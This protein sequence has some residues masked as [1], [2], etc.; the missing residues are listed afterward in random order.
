MAQQQHGPIVVFGA[1]GRAGLAIASE[2]L[3]RRRRVIGVVRDPARHLEL[4]A[5]GDGV[6]LVEGDLTDSDSVTPVMAGVPG[7][8]AVLVSAVTPFSAP[9]DSFDDF[10][11]DYYVHLVQNLARAAATALCRVI[12]IGHIATLRVGGRRLFEDTA[13]F[14]EFLRPFAEARLRGL[15]AWQEQATV[16]WLVITPPPVL[17][18]EASATGRYRLAGD[19]LDAGSAST[20]LSYVDLAVAVMDQID[21]PTF[22]RR[23]VTAYG[24][25]ADSADATGTPT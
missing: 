3:R 6:T 22:H 12:E 4:A 21:T 11:A 7:D 1:G 13:A 25:T 10:D 8:V 2:S 23:Q 9:P 24:L 15:V 17:S 5:L 19:V 18:S 20:P 16:D 14:P